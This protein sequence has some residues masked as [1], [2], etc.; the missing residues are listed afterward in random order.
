MN[1]N[2][3]FPD[4]WAR[5]KLPDIAQLIMGQSPPSLTYNTN[6]EGLPFYQGKSEFGEVYPTPKIWCG[7]PNKIAEAGDIIIS[8]R[9][10]VGPT[11]MIK[12]K[13]CIGRGLA[14][15]RPL[16]YERY[17][18]L[19]YLRHIEKD[20][21]ALG[22]GSTFTAI[23][24]TH[25][26][27]IDV[28]LPP[29][30]EQR[31]IVARIES[32][33]QEVKT[34][35]ESLDKLPPIIKR[36]RQSVLANAFKGEL[37]PQDPEDEP[38]SLLLEHIR[39][40]RKKKMGKNYREPEAVGASGLPEIPE[41]WEWT[42]LEMIA[43]Q[44]LGKMLDGNKNVGFPHPYLGNIN[45]RWFGFDLENLK[46]IKITEDEI[47]NI[48]LKKGDLAVCEGGEPGR[49]A[50]WTENKPIVIQKAIHRVRLEN[51]MNP[52]FI[53]YY[54]STEADSKRLEKSFTGTTIKHLTGVKIRRYPIPLPPSPEQ[55][56][57]VTKIEQLFALANHLEQSLEI[58]RKRT[59]RLEQSILAKAFRGELVPQDPNDEPASV[60]L[61]RIR[62]ERDKIKMTKSGR[63]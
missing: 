24:K 32:L 46:T 60:L 5:V 19:N 3:I 47:E 41:G 26:E 23:S 20:I 17:L 48:S 2:W 31:R 30:P 40:E 37:V 11:N 22:T 57:I 49:A 35:R 13:S 21:A 63:K 45:I 42:A 12:E 58:A 54:F 50:V 28:P 34:A 39:E 8:V 16:L 59:D 36:F 61:D 18:L 56:R 38:A 55:H 6:K 7:E 44:R 9:A 33:F 15:I 1:K 10:P 29:L 14:A 62:R 25:L 51:G 27:D 43:E 53:A 4:N 52:W